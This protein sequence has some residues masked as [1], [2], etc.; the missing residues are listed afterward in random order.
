MPISSHWPVR[1]DQAASFARYAYRRFMA[2]RCLR[3]AASLSYTSL[4][5]VVPLTAIAFAILAAFPVFED[6]RGEFQDIVF[7]NL[8]PETAEATREYFE[9]F[10]LNT[11]GLTALGVVGLALT[12]VLLLGTVEDA[13]NRLFRVARRRALIPRLLVFWALLTLGPLLLGASFSV[14]GYV[15]A[16][17]KL[18]GGELAGGLVGGLTWA[19]PTLLVVAAMAVFFIIIPNRRVAVAEGLFGAVVG[20]LLFTLL[21]KGFGLY[22]SNFPA[23]QTIYG[24]MS[25]VPIFLVWMYLSWAVVLFGATMS[26]AL[27][28]W[29][30][31]AGAP[32]LDDPKPMERLVA[33]L[34][35]LS[36][37]Q[38]GRRD[39]KGATRQELL[40]RARLSDAPGSALLNDLRKARYLERADGGVWFLARD[41]ENVTLDAFMRSLGVGYE[42]NSELSEDAGWSGRLAE[43]LKTLSEAQSSHAALSLRS[44]LDE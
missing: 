38:A 41:L 19:A 16:T 36:L 25:A 26:A 30:R 35:I 43:R 24:A 12:A 29:R 27:G 28:E 4:L 42:L 6:V 15:F 1:P 33:G 3:V 22:V 2:D 44:L 34:A 14:S 39:G 21:R 11:A 37:L 20:G 23:Y 32:A 18:M 13:M 40:E 5:A 7:S 8:L 31:A 10:V 17:T 9:R